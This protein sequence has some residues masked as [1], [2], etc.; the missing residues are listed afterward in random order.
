MVTDPCGPR[1]PLA[2]KWLEVWGVIVVTFLKTES[3]A[4]ITPQTS[5]HLCASGPL[6]PQGSVTI[7]CV[8]G[9]Y[10]VESR[11]KATVTRSSCVANEAAGSDVT[12]CLNVKLKERNV[13]LYYLPLWIGQYWIKT[14]KDFADK[15]YCKTFPTEACCTPI[16]CANKEQEEAKKELEEAK[17][18]LKEQAGLPAPSV[19]SAELVV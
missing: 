5:N 1:G 15:G 18:A 11:C 7:S 9:R 10:K 12:F 17:K 6:G 4:T 14:A 19:I 16:A 3:N 8:E 13:H 2:H